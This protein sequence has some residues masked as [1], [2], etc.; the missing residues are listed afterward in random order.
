MAARWS[1]AASSLRTSRRTSRK[2][3]LSEACRLSGICSGGPTFRCNR[4]NCCSSSPRALFP[5]DDL[6][7]LRKHGRKKS[8]RLKSRR[9][10]S[11]RFFYGRRTHE[12]T[13]SRSGGIGRQETGLPA[14][15][16]SGELVLPDGFYWGIRGAGHLAGG[17]NAGD[18]RALYRAS[19][20]RDQRSK[21]R[22]ATRQFVRCRRDFSSKKS[23]GQG[24]IRRESL[25]ARAVEC[26]A[27][28]PGEQSTGS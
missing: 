9:R 4:R 21:S 14:G 23:A 10:K 26:P 1:L 8:V 15:D 27:K 28:G 11:P 18:R 7:R 25:D 16:A 2:C 20:G 3:R 5:D 19:E 17:R 24:R 22:A 13:K 6:G 12:K